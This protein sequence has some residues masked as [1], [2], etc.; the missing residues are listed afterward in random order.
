MAHLNSSKPGNEFVR[1]FVSSELK[2]FSVHKALI[3]STCDFF[4]NA[5]DGRFMEG[6]KNKM[7]MPE[8]DPD[9]FEIFVNW[10]HA[11]HLRSDLK[12]M[13]IINLWIFADKC[14]CQKLENNALDAL[15]HALHVDNN[16][17]SLSLT[18][19]EVERIFENTM[20]NDT[21]SCR[22]RGF[23]VKL[24]AFEVRHGDRDKICDLERIFQGVDGSLL[25]TLNI[26]RE[27]MRLDFD[28][29]IRNDNFCRCCGFPN[30]IGGSQLH[31]CI[32]PNTVIRPGDHQGRFSP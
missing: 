2:E 6:V 5:F 9:T 21:N 29:R 11:G 7:F 32:T 20:E 1:I 18:Y 17:P 30:H 13:Q 24:L 3:R 10:M 14:Q 23:A 12:P 28:P 19:E 8:D 25:E 4:K 31:I 27:G 26:I 16:S 15:V 22:L